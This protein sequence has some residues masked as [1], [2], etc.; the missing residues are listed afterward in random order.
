MFNDKGELTDSICQFTLENGKALMSN[1]QAFLELIKSGMC[2]SNTYNTNFWFNYFA[3]NRGYAPAKYYFGDGSE[4]GTADIRANTLIG[5]GLQILS[6]TGGSEVAYITSAGKFVTKKS[7]F[8][9]ELLV[10]GSEDSAYTGYALNVHGKGIATKGFTIGTSSNSNYALNVTG[11][12]LIDGVVV[13]S[14][15]KLKDNINEVSVNALEKLKKVRFYSYDRKE[16]IN[17]KA[18][19]HIKMGIMA[20]EA[21]DEI[22]N[23]TGDA[24]DLYSYSS[25]LAKAVQELTEKLEQ[26]AK[27][28]EDLKSKLNEK[29]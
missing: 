14:D 27:E 4:G 19:L 17:E 12:C 7:V 22:L 13:S 24:V 20:D 23:Q 18:A 8:A 5:N 11:G 21:P 26:Q 28:I 9:K 16:K 2:L 15:R 3:P 10:V 29:S 1:G 6:G 25:F